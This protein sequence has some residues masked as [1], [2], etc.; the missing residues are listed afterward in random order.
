MDE[1]RNLI[2]TS[3]NI[4]WYANIKVWIRVKAVNMGTH[5][6]KRW[7]EGFIWTNL[8]HKWKSM[9]WNVLR[10]EN[11][12]V[13]VGSRGGKKGLWLVWPWDTGLIRFPSC[14][15]EASS[16]LPI[17]YPW[18]EGCWCGF[19]TL[20]GA[21]MLEGGA[22]AGRSEK[23]I[24][25]TPWH[26]LSFPGWRKVRFQAP[27]ALRSPNPLVDEVRGETPGG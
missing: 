18:K 4:F 17:F 16:H 12:E 8:G 9:V 13:M 1:S 26:P 25:R 6:C 24:D 14:R 21:K 15:D 23:I 27:L 11:D 7:Y 2:R 10:R 20:K 3:S 5:S 22:L 19:V